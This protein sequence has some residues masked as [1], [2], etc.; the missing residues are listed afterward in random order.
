MIYDI[1]RRFYNRL[2][3]YLSSFHFSVYKEEHSNTFSD[4][5]YR[6]ESGVHI[7]FDVEY[8]DQIVII[9]Y[10]NRYYHENNPDCYFVMGNY[11]ELLDFYE[12]QYS[13]DCI[14]INKFKDWK[15]FEESFFVFLSETFP[16]IVSNVNAEMLD[17]IDR[18]GFEK[19]NITDSFK[20]SD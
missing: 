14:K 13:L 16:L 20:K 5:T 8:L 1:E 17:D 18:A 12:I 10:G 4:V 7:Q 3:E 2:T 11:M 19:M 6:N 15:S 9:K